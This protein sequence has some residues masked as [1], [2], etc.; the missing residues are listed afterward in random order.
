MLIRSQDKTAL[1]KF[2]N[3]VVN[4]KLPDSLSVIC[5]S[6]QDAQRS[7]GY[8]ILGKYSTKEKAMKVL[9]MIQEA[10]AD[11]ELNEIL[12]PDVYKAANKSQQEKEN[13]SIAKDIRNAFMKKMVFQMPDDESVEV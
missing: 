3:I 13:T 4:P 2:E 12:L 1:V 8:F 10:Y 9:D 5:W 7:G 6:W 11:A